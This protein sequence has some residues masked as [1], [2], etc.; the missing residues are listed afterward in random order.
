MGIKGLN[1]LLNK[2]CSLTH[3][4]LVP[5]SNFAG[6]KV[7]VDATL[8]ACIFK[9]RPSFTDAIIEMITTLLENKI[10]PI[11]IFDGHAPEEKSNERKERYEKREA[12]QIRIKQLE[13]DLESY[14][15]TGIMTDEL[16]KI[17]CKV[18]KL[19]QLKINEKK[20]KDHIDR[21]KLQIEPITSEDFVTMKSAFG[22][23][24]ITAQSEAEFTCAAMARHGIVDAVI[25]RDTDAI[26]CLSP[27]TII[28]IEGCYFR[29]I[30]LDKILC[31]MNLTRESFQD[32]CI[33]CGTD[34]NKNI[35]G[36]GP[37]KSL[38]LINKYNNIE[39]I[40]L[41]VS[42]L[43]FKRVREI[44][45]FCDNPPNIDISLKNNKVDF[46]KLSEFYPNVNLIKSRLLPKQI[47][48]IL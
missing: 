12:T 25:T 5:I 36:V 6:K 33:L 44:F 34:F 29:I 15:K 28:N 26:A 35:P 27:K 13:Q 30:Y 37:I 18:R 21:M 10:Q 8:Y 19:V 3:V 1:Q 24:Y 9:N 23:Y 38:E 11:F 45:S 20:I 31:K 4:S 41:D 39:N 42:C 16:K 46:D 7:A 14:K 48:R 43:N 32:L 17:D 47:K 40:P 22:V 2:M